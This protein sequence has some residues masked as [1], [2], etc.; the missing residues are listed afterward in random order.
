M[1]CS[2]RGE[3]EVRMASVWWEP[4][5]FMWE[6]ASEIV[7]TVLIAKTRERCSVP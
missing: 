7:E 6:I 2:A 5:V 4:W 1:N 3:E